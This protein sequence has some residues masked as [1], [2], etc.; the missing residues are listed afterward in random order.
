ML[1]VVPG[2]ARFIERESRVVAAR[3]GRG[4]VGGIVRG[5]GVYVGM[6]E[7]VLELDGGEICMILCPSLVL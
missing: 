4:V 6:D 1:C 2:E 5:L 7:K 3:P